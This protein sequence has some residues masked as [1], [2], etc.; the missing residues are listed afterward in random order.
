V[1]FLGADQWHDRA[2]NPNHAADE[3][4]DQN[5][6]RELPPIGEQSEGDA[7]RA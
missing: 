6:Q 3:G 4:V 7:A 1:K 2:L 5:Q